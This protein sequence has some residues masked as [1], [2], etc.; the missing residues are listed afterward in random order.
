MNEDFNREEN[1][2]EEISDQREEKKAE[3]KE[4]PEYAYKTVMDV[5][6]R[7]RIWSVASAACAVMSIMLCC[8]AWCALAFGVLAI[9]F[10]IVSRNRI[11]YFDN[12]GL[13]GLIVGIFGVVFGVTGLVL[14]YLIENTDIFS[15]ILNEME[16]NGMQI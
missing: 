11:G 13:V 5:K 10:A 1:S 15:D 7:S 6:E 3:E 4:A 14:T 8:T 2:E 9:V 16:K 12:I